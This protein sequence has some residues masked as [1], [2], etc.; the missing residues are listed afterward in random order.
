MG[1]KFI[2][3]VWLVV[4]FFVVFSLALH[5]SGYTLKGYLPAYGKNA[6]EYAPV[7]YAPPGDTPK[8]VLYEMG[9]GGGITYYY[10]WST[11]ET[12][13][14]LIDRLY[15]YI[16]K[17]FYGSET[18]IEPITIYPENRTVIFESYNHRKVVATFDD[19]NCYTGNKTIRNCVVNGTHVKV[20][21]V[22]WNH[23]FSLYPKTGTIPVNVTPEP[24]SPWEYTHYA[25]FKRANES[26]KE[27]ALRATLIAIVVTATINI[28]GYYIFVKRRAGKK[29]KEKL[30]KES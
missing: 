27:A 10:I 22:T 1:R 21:V 6:L 5:E 24:M 25:I 30:R 17:L 4:N 23:A 2:I 7:I 18:D 11:E 20:Y 12:G 13:K 29:L 15:D 16:R 19:Y 26:I 28:M 14:L 8:K 3:A 9:T